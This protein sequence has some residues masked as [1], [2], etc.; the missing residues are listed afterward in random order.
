MLPAVTDVPVY[1]TP[2][3]FNAPAALPTTPPTPS[4]VPVITPD[5]VEFEIV[6]VA[7][8]V[9]QMPPTEATP[10]TEVVTDT[11]DIELPV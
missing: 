5:T 4:P 1:C 3:K 6:A 10:V 7:L 11:F 9:P 2:N 8:L